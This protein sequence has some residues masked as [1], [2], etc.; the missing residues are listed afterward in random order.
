MQ[1]VISHQVLLT[2]CHHSHQ[3]PLQLTVT[4]TCRPQQCCTAV[5][6]YLGCSAPKGDFTSTCHVVCLLIQTTRQTKI[7]DLKEASKHSVHIDRIE[8][9][10]G[11]L[12]HEYVTAKCQALCTLPTWTHKLHFALNIVVSMPKVRTYVFILDSTKCLMSMSHEP[13]DYCTTTSGEN[14]WSHELSFLFRFLYCQLGAHIA[15]ILVHSNAQQLPTAEYTE[16]LR[17]LQWVE[18]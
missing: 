13:Q 14:V 10:L 5:C 6:A 16:L 11:W 4:L 12:P 2:Q 17:L 7:R 3:M 9:S 8:E 15:Y 18:L 1:V